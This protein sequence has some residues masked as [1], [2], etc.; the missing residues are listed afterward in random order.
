M[1]ESICAEIR[2][3]FTKRDDK[4]FG[5]FTISNG[6][7]LL[8]YPVTTGYIRIWD[9]RLNDGTYKVESE[10][11]VDGTYHVK[12]EGLKDETFDGAVWIMSP[13]KDFLAVVSDIEA[14][15]K[16]YGNVDGPSYS[17]FTSESFAGTYSYSK[18]EGSGDGK[19]SGGWQK[20]F[21]ERLDVYRRLR[22]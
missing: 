2:N 19:A 1:I 4:H 5:T 20:A 17:P 18:S 14:W 3:Y 13:P 21:A 12:A 22:T 10:T 9:S 6:E 8:P 7:L 16:K 11:H 15:E